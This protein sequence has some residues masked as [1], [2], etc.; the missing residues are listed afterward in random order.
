M[1]NNT[2]TQQFANSDKNEAD[3]GP[4]INV[5]TV[6]PLEDEIKAHFARLSQQLVDVANL[7]Q[8]MTRNIDPEIALGL[9][10]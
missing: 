10:Y 4:E 8:G 6:V 5:T 9:S 7:I 3:R 2:E 1:N